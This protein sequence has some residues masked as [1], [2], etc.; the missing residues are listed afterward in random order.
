MHGNS[1]PDKGGSGSFFDWEGNRGSGVAW[2]YVTTESWVYQP[3]GKNG[4]GITTIVD[5]YGEFCAKE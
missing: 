2:P 5:A 3:S 4:L 1:V